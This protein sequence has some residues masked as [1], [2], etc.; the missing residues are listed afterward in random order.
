MRRRLAA[1]AAVVFAVALFASPAL[2][3]SGAG[4]RAGSTIIAHE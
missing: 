2:A 4:G 1:L 3:K